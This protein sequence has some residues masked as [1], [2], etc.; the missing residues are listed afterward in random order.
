MIKRRHVNAVDS[1]RDGDQRY[2]LWTFV[3]IG[4]VKFSQA[5]TGRRKDPNHYINAAL[6][7]NELQNLLLFQADAEA[8]GL[9][10]RD[11]T[12]NRSAGLKRSGL[13]LSLGPFDWQKACEDKE[14]RHDS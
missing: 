9:T 13:A 1:R 6:V 10:T 4:T 5:L 8:M 11:R 2:V 14:E 3:A 7:H 12:L